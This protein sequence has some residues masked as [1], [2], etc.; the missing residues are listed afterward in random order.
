MKLAFSRPSTSKLSYSY[1]PCFPSYPVDEFKPISSIGEKIADANSVVLRSATES[2]L[3]IFCSCFPGKG[4][5]D[6]SVRHNTARPY[7]LID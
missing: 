3:C 6:G 5:K 1:R 7:T 2:T 4:K